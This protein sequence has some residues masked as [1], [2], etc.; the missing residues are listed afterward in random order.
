MNIYQDAVDVQAACNVS[1]IIN[2]LNKVKDE[3]WEEIRSG[4]WQGQLSDHPAIFL[5]IFQLSFLTGGTSTDKWH[6]AYTYCQ[7]K[8]KEAA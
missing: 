2:S 8:A 7:Q 4:K 5:F 1:G 3:V 6:E